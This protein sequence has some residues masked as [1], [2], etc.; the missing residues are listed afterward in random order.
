MA[1]VQERSPKMSFQV[2]YLSELVDRTAVV[3]GNGTQAVVGK[4]ID[5]LVAMPEGTFPV[6]DGLVVKTR[7]GDRTSP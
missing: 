7:S 1:G 3:A 2:G 4:V 6:I 5:F